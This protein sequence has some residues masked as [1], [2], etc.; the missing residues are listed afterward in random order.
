[1]NTIDIQLYALS[2]WTDWVFVGN[3]NGSRVAQEASEQLL[4]LPGGC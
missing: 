3:A 4:R 1:M 2:V